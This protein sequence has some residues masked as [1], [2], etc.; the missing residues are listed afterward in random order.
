MR[1]PSGSALRLRTGAWIVG[2]LAAAAY[3]AYAAFPFLNVRF[4]TY[5]DEGYMLAILGGTSSGGDLYDQVFSQYGPF[6]NEFYNGLFW[7]LRLPFDHDA[8]RAVTL[9][10][11]VLVSVVTGLAVARVTR[12]YA[13]GFAVQVLVFCSM[14]WAANEPLHPV[15]LTS[16]L[17]AA[18]FLASSA[19]DEGSRLTALVLGVLLGCLILVKINVGLIALAAVMIAV[20]FGRGRAAQPRWLSWGAAAIFVLLPVVL[21]AKDLD[22]TLSF[23][24]LVSCAAVSVLLAAVQGRARGPAP[25]PTDRVL[26]LLAGFAGA[27]SIVCCLTLL[28]GTS[29]R[30]LLDGVLLNPLQQSEAFSIPLVIPGPAIAA[31]IGAAVLI[32][33]LGHR[34][35]TDPSPYLVTGLVRLAGA[36]LITLAVARAW[37]GTYIPYALPLIGLGALPRSGARQT[38][39]RLALPALAVMASLHAYPVAGSQTGAAS[40]LFLPVA[41]VCAVDAVRDL[42]QWSAQRSPRQLFCGAATAGAAVLALLFAA[43]PLARQFDKGWARYRVQPSLELPGAGR[44]HLDAGTVRHYQGLALGLRATCSTFYG[45]PG[46]NSLY[47]FAGVPPVTGY[48]ATAWMYLFDDAQESQ[49]ARALAADRRSCVLRDEPLSAAWQQGRPLPRGPIVELI[50][51]EYVPLRLHGSSQ[52]LVHRER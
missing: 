36:L 13:A 17:L 32:A 16:F 1:E 51:A 4:A 48:N 9:A 30:G 43:S 18:V 21:M 15:V 6:F 20:L 12:S 25:F 29:L 24:V 44:I 8:G 45:L 28:R 52:L 47:L 14:T 2:T 22:T 33:F 34:Q 41:G 19:L 31:G 50:E 37:G 46:Q 5:D 10:G 27:A 23:A 49:V 3:G 26:P 39:S 7:L 11:W 42:L 35:R 38:T 40:F